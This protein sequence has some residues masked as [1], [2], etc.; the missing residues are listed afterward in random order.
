MKRISIPLILIFMFIP[1]IVNAETLSVTDCNN[2]K[3]NTTIPSNLKGLAKIIAQNAY[4]DNGKSEYVSSCEGVKFNDISSDTNGKGIYEIAST[5]NDAYPIYY[6]RGAVDN[7]NI[8]FGGFCWKAIR[9][10]ETGGVKMIYNGKPDSNGNCTNTTGESTQIS[11]STFNN[12]DNSLAYVGYMYGT[13]YQYRSKHSS[14]INSSYIYGKDVTYSGGTYTLTNTKA[15]TGTWS[16]DYD[17]LNN[18]HYTCYSTETTCSNVYYIYYT[19]SSYAY[20]ITLKDGKKIEDALDDMFNNTNDSVAKSKIDTWYNTNLSS[21]TNYLEDTIY[22]N[23]I[24]VGEINGWNPNG[25]DTKEV[26]SFS[27]YTR[28]ETNYRPSLTCSRKLDQF[29]VS[30]SKGNGKLT[31]PVGLITTDEIMYAGG[32]F[33]TGNSSYYLNTNQDYWSLTPVDFN[34]SSSARNIELYS[35]GSTN[36][37]SVVTEGGLRPVISLKSPVLVEFGDGTKTNPYII[38]YNHSIFVEDNK[39]TKNISFNIEDISSVEVGKTV[40][41]KIVPIDGYV[42]DHLVLLDINNNE[43]SFTSSGNENEYSFIMPETNVT[44]RTFYNKEVNTNNNII[45]NTITGI[46][47]IGLLIVFI[48]GIYIYFVIRKRYKQISIEN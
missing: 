38:N 30:S 19:N 6:Y 44:I 32:K 7:N 24:S 8:K 26:L 37:N 13:V 11:T 40:T 43:V 15:S 33:N 14:N 48:I 46:T 16:N 35:S 5:K 3:L 28:T 17:T 39:Q 4:L 47:I 20:Y 31:Y 2:N 22:C 1:F 42:L 41:F 27:S 45:T 34:I 23:D 36:T 21:Y 10:T 9:T 29:T 25:G 18:H 12:Y